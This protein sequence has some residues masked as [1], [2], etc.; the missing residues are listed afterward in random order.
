MTIAL[1][2]AG[3]QR[4]CILLRSADLY[5]ALVIA[6]VSTSAAA[7]T[8]RQ[9]VQQHGCSIVAPRT[10]LFP[11]VPGLRPA[12]GNI[13]VVPRDA[14]LAVQRCRDEVLDLAGPKSHLLPSINIY[15]RHVVYPI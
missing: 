14:K 10:Y 13:N 2:V 7:W 12:L 4:K 6:E 8:A 15:P 11:L 1:N 5:E 3:Y 9:T